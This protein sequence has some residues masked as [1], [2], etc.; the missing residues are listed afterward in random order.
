ML[1]HYLKNVSKKGKSKKIKENKEI[2]TS[3]QHIQE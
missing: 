1:A 3:L 2:A